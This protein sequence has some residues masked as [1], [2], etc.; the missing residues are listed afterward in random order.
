MLTQMLPDY[1]PLPISSLKSYRPFTDSDRAV[2]LECDKDSPLYSEIRQL[3]VCVPEGNRR[4]L[5]SVTVLVPETRLE[6]NCKAS[7]LE[8][9][10][11]HGRLS[12]VIDE[13]TYSGLPEDERL[14][15]ERHPDGQYRMPITTPLAREYAKSYASV[16]EA[17]TRWN[18]TPRKAR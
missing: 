8:V 17:V 13:N 7:E 6:K 10:V 16:F 5:D 11:D 12:R 18:S 2:T 15:F 1:H 4:V 14:Y 3:L 9:N